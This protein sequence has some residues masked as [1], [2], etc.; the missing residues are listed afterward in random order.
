MDG[1]KH[2]RER[3]HV[4]ADEKGEQVFLP[5]LF[6]GEGKGRGEKKDLAD[7]DRRGKRK[8]AQV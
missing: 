8:H 2:E 7:C 6:V 4:H 5:L 1:R 3:E